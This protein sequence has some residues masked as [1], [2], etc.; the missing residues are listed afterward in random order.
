VRRV[1]LPLLTGARVT[2]A[3]I[4]RR[5]ERAAGTEDVPILRLEGVE[6]RESAAALTGELIQVPDE[7]PPLDDGEWLAGDLI[8]CEV[9]GAGTVRRVIAGPSCD[10]L[11]LDDGT[12]VPLVRDAIEK[13]DLDARR[14]EIDR[15]FLGLA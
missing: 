1:E 13:I 6:E 12:L 3:G 9:A 4:E 2:V 8:G 14:I 10:V 5:I 15:H 11:E 7:C